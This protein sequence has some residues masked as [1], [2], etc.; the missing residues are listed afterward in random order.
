MKKYFVSLFAIIIIFSACRS[1]KKEPENNFIPVL[2][3]IKGQVAHVDTSLYSIIKVV[4]RDTL[5]GDTT[6]IPREEF[7]AAA[8]DFLA[9]PDLSEEK[10]AKR[11]KQEQ[12]FDETIGR[13]ITTYTPVN[14]A[15]EEIQKQ[16]FLVDPNITTRVNID[17]II[18]NLV[19]T[20]RDSSI[21][22]NML[23]QMDRSFQVTTILQKPG[24]PEKTTTVKVKWN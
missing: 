17:N 10:M 19:I 21:Q 3:I 5:Q 7:R 8:T 13:L 24:M 20:N 11:Y 1:K 22:K 12:L 23:W 2:S 4:T 14:P 6:Y 15:T 18:I 16:E 9:I